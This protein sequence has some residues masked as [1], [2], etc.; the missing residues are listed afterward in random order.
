MSD[1]PLTI[2]GYDPE[3]I[4]RVRSICLYVASKLG[5]L[6]DDIVIVGGLVP[7]LLVDQDK[8]PWG[9]NPHGGTMDLD[10]GLSLALLDEERYRELRSRLLDAEFEQDVNDA[11]RPTR[12]RWR[13]T[14]EQ[15]I[16]VD[17]LISPGR[18]A[19]TGGR[20]LDIEPD[21]AAVIT[22][23]LELAFRD[24]RRVSLSGETPRGERATREVWVCGPGAFTVLKTLAFVGRGG[25]KDAYDLFY[26]WK[27][28]G[29]GEVTRCL[30]RFRDDPLV[31]RALEILARDFCHH[32]GLGP[33]R[34]ARFLANDAASADEIQA[35][36]VGLARDLVSALT[37]ALA[38]DGP[39]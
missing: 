4:G 38:V 21:F 8:L 16:T 10:L 26:V 28:L 33:K 3:S 7:A 23:G 37:A 14:F 17:F 29:V 32:D 24:R 22:P 30:D 35:D 39:P 18:G 25:N 11:G 5:D 15:P 13:T 31:K 1:K 2:D 9:V 36:V 19:A 34:T 27:G 12:Q 20:L 6:L